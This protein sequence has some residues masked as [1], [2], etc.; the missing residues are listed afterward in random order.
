MKVIG[1]RTPWII[2]SLRKRA[3]VPPAAPTA[4][5]FQSLTANGTSGTVSTTQLTATFDVDPGLTTANFVVTGA[6]K[7]VVS[8]V[9][10]VYTININTITVDDGQSVTLDIVGVPS[11]FTVTPTTRTVVVNKAAALEAPTFIFDLVF[12]AITEGDSGTFSAAYCFAGEIDSYS[13]AS[14]TLPAWLTF[15]TATAVFTYTNAVFETV[16]GLSITAT[17]AAGSATTNT[18]DWVVA[19]DVTG[20]GTLTTAPSP[21]YGYSQINT[22]GIT[23]SIGFIEDPNGQEAPV[24]IAAFANTTMAGS[25]RLTTK[26]LNG[27]EHAH[28]VW[29]LTKANGDPI[30]EEFDGI[31]NYRFNSA[32]G[33]VEGTDVNVHTG[34]IS[35]EFTDLMLNHGDYKLT[36]KAYGMTSDNVNALMATD[37]YTFSVA[38]PTN[39]HIY[40]DPVGGNDANDGFDPLGLSLTSASYV[41]STGILTQTGAFAGLVLDGEQYDTDTADFLS[42]TGFGRARIAEVID[43]NS[44]RI[45]DRWKLG[46]D[47][48]GLTSSNGPKQSVITTTVNNTV[49]HYIVPAEGIDLPAPIDISTRS[50]HCGI[51]SCGSGLDGRMYSSSIVPDTNSSSLILAGNPSISATSPDKFMISR[52][53]LDSQDVQSVPIRSGTGNGNEENKFNQIYRGLDLKRA[54]ANS[55]IGPGTKKEGDGA[56]LGIL[57]WGCTLNNLVTI[58]RKKTIAMYNILNDRSHMRCIG[59]ITDNDVYDTDPV[60]YEADVGSGLYHHWYPNGNNDHFHVGWCYFRSGTGSSY[61]IN[62]NAGKYLGPWTRYG[63]SIHDSYLG[64]AVRG[65]D[66]SN[67][68]NEDEMFFDNVYVA[69]CQSNLTQ[70]F[71][72]HY[73]AKSIF[74]TNI[75][76]YASDPVGS[77]SFFKGKMLAEW[78]YAFQN[79][80]NYGPSL[81]DGETTTP[82][83]EFFDS[84]SVA[85]RDSSVFQIRNFY[86]EAS[87]STFTNVVFYSPNAPDGDVYQISGVLSP[88]ATLNALPNSADN[89]E[90]VI[91]WTD[92]PPPALPQGVSF[93]SATANGESGVTSSNE[94]TITFNKDPGAITADDFTIT[95]DEA[96][97]GALLGTGT[98]RVLAIS[99]IT[100]LDS[101]TINIVIADNNGNTFLPNNR[102]VTVYKAVAS[103]LYLNPPNDSAALLTYDVG[104]SDDTVYD[105]QGLRFKM[106]TS[107][108]VTVL[109]GGIGEGTSNFIRFKPTDNGGNGA[110]NLR[111]GGAFS[112][113]TEFI[114][115]LPSQ[116]VLWKGSEVL[117]DIPIIANDPVVIYVDGTP[118]SHATITFAATPQFKFDFLRGNGAYYT[119]DIEIYDIATDE[120]LLRFD[121]DSGTIVGT[122]SAPVGTGTLTLN[123]SEGDWT[124]T[125]A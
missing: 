113:S 89:A 50:G 57:I 97:K 108:I 2:G 94:I 35:P 74:V 110:V 15:N 44:V 13:I 58:P 118:Y 39:N 123:V 36:L 30:D 73:R 87:E 65:I 4:V 107:D 101:E 64:A 46:S 41:E 111:Q 103:R 7:G 66:F 115:N 29:E 80:R 88:L 12:P 27:Y 32:T 106:I 9:G 11:G 55:I 76:H 38:K 100:V 47:Q 1:R 99:D 25:R 16:S 82:T 84:E 91:T 51:Y 72:L 104:A 112:Q 10:A 69:R 70:D 68:S 40:I 61:C 105:G 85:T 26:P 8:K 120:V 116:S 119:Y 92:W 77:S 34:T 62:T 53:E 22:T 23:T 67:H 75:D 14:G 124:D 28:H 52:L 122:E 60:E 71:I 17:N 63:V 114:I 54:N 43:D 96:T 95:D 19:E 98:T 117:F 6:S 59:V 102:D 3:F 24:S 125:P 33:L 18:A 86:P 79:I 49:Y 93:V 31:K 83:V 5:S 109:G 81:Y 90:G 56:A 37:E 45:D 78:S 21:Y 121:V 48:T 20:D 42:L